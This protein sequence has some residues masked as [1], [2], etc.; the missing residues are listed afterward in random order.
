MKRTMVGLLILTAVFG[1]S[2]L[3]QEGRGPNSPPVRQSVTGGSS[4]GVAAI[5]RA[6]A[7][8]KF[9][10][11]FFW[12]EKNQ[13]TD[14]AWRVLQPAAAKM[15]DWAEVAAV[16]VTDPAEQ[17]LVARYDLTR[18]PLPLVLAIAPCGAITKGFT[19]KFTEEQLRAAYVSPCTQQCLKALQDKKL[20]LLCVADQAGPNAAAVVPPG[21]RDFK[22]DKTYGGATEI[23]FINASD[24]GEATFLKELQVNPKAPKPCSVLLA[25]PGT[26][27]GQF[28]GRAS[29]EQ[30]VAKL[31]AA[32]NNP[33]AGGKCGPNGCGPKK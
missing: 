22:A 6:A 26:V 20:V 21:V 25:P 19:G 28:D 7:A 10:F 27:I 17:E 5:E 32:Q 8:R 18:T 33:C 23:V 29:K 12:K 31:V 13:P 11:V 15:T 2:A 4:Q 1:V 24:E 16:Q 9:I 3:A 30:I 14:Q